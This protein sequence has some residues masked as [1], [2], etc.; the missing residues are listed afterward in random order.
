MTTPRGD[1]RRVR[2][3]SLAVAAMAA[4]LVL[5][6]PSVSTTDAAFTD[7]EHASTTVRAYV[8]PRP[9]IEN[10]CTTSAGLLGAAPTITIVWTLPAGY[11]STD[12][13][14]GIGAT[15]TTLAKVTTNSATTSLGSGRYRTVFSGGLLSGLLGGSASVGVRI[16][17]APK[18]NWTS[19]WSTATG[20]IALLGLGTTCT[21]NA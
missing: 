19:T 8:V 16:L 5:V 10:P 18:N 3:L 21:V 4:T 2:L 15:A 20:S 17:D 12:V 14:Y 7:A 9:P 13:E 6:V 1:R 11:A